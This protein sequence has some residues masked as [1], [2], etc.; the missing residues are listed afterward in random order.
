MIIDQNY[1]RT[2]IYISVKHEDQWPVQRQR[3]WSLLDPKCTAIEQC[4]NWRVLQH[5]SGRSMHTYRCI[6]NQWH[7]L[8]ISQYSYPLQPSCMNV[9]ITESVTPTRLVGPAAMCPR[10]L[11]H[12]STPAQE[13]YIQHSFLLA[14]F[15]FMHN[16]CSMKSNRPACRCARFS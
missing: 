7:G 6:W 16:L 2:D 10:S 1:S 9:W 14:L 3:R 15:Y 13:P 12:I 5:C 8:H 4:S 11:T